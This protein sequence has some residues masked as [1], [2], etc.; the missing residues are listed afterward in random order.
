LGWREFYGRRY[1][2]GPGV[3]IP[4]Q[5]TEVLVDAALTRFDTQLTPGPSVL[6][7]GT[8]SGCIAISLKLEN[9]ILN[10]VASDLSH[11]AMDIARQNATDLGAEIRFVESDGFDGLS[12]EQFDAIVT[13]PPYIGTQEPLATEVAG[14]EPPEALYAGTSG[15]EFFE[16]LACEA[17]SYLRP[18]GWILTEV[19]YR[20]SSAV[21]DLFCREGW[22]HLDTLYDLSGIARAVLCAK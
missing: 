5:E 8:G 15:L 4:R 2:V 18:G 3:L 16:R 20:Q 13:N 19:G 22:T 14:Y 1:A 21:S 17:S 6:D 9:P 12:E 7:L 11:R 10:V